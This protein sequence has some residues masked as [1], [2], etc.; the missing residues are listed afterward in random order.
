[1]ADPVEILSI[2]LHL[3]RAS[4][5]RRRPHVRDR[6]LV[7]A[8]V[9]ATRAGLLRIAAYCR[10]LV[11]QHNAQHL[12]RRWPT[13]AV[14]LRDP[15]FQHFLAHLEKRYSRENAEQLLE[16]LAIER[17]REREA[18]YSDEEYVASIL[19]ISLESLYAQFPGDTTD[20][21]K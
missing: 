2:Y 12:I 16:S 7:L 1:M 10:Q 21:A 14:A 4:E 19:S 6:L 15:E 20:P 5:R 9:A 3:A 13:V 8:A 18:Y 17:G 11:V